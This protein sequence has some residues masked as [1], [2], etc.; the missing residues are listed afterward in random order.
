[1]KL[2]GQLP[3]NNFADRLQITR[4]SQVGAGKGDHHFLRCRVVIDVRPETRYG[5]VQID[6][7]DGQLHYFPGA[8]KLVLELASR[9]P[10]VGIVAE[11]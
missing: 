6:R 8:G 2:P 5:V 9:R 1:M 4:I 3:G 11:Q 7:R 10:S